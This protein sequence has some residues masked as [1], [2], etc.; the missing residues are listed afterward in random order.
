MKELKQKLRKF[1]ENR[2]RNQF[3]NAKN[4]AILIIAYIKSRNTCNREERHDSDVVMPMCEFDR[5]ALFDKE[6]ISV[7]NGRFIQLLKT[8]ITNELECY[9][10]KLKDNVCN[11]YNDMTKNYF[12]W[13]YNHHK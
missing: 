9:I 4:L 8:P 1:T 2:N 11:Y 3:N 13:H 6:S 12:D 5:D 7:K 10:S